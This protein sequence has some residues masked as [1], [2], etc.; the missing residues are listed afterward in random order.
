[1]NAILCVLFER[2]DDADFALERDIGNDLIMF[3]LDLNSVSRPEFNSVNDDSFY[4]ARIQAHLK[5]HRRLSLLQKRA[6]EVKIDIFSAL[7][8]HP[9]QQITQE[10]GIRQA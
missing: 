2:L 7:M 6:C 3:R 8:R 5:M 1:M 10:S 9:L 4:P